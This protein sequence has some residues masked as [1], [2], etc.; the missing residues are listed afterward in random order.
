M[1]VTRTTVFTI[2]PILYIYITGNIVLGMRQETNKARG[3]AEC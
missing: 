1:V 2:L 3:V